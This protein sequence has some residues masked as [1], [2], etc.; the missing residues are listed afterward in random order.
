MLTSTDVKAVP[1]NEDGW[2]DTRHMCRI[3]AAS[4]VRLSTLRM[5]VGCGRSPMRI[6]SIKPS[7]LMHVAIATSNSPIGNFLSQS[8]WE[9]PTW[10]CEW[11]Q[12]FHRPLAPSSHGGETVSFSPAFGID[13]PSNCLTLQ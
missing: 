10:K 8:L 9:F 11:G 6:A 4:A 3:F 1:L 5:S 13:P 12:G 2:P 7:M